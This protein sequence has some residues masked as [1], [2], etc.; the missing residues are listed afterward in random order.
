VLLKQKGFNELLFLGDAIEFPS[1]GFATTERRLSEHRD[2]VKRVLKSLYR[3]LAFARDR[4]DETVRI[5]EREWRLEPG[6]AQES[7]ASIMKAASKD[8]T[9]SEAG[10]KV[11]AQIIQSSEKGLGD[12]PLAKMVDFRLIQEI[13]RELGG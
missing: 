9:A 8:G 5:I 12:I 1:N 10:L 4:P 6:A 3:G 2:Q 11:H 13:R 7:Y